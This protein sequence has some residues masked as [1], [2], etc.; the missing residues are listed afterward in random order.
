MYRVDTWLLHRYY[1][2]VLVSLLG[3]K[4][5]LTVNA[6]CLGQVCYWERKERMFWRLWHQN[7][8]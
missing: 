8:D 7:Y 4:N 5:I 2:Y 3:D 6:W 1:K